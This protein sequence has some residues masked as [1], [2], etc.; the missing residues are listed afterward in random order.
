M[1]R[2]PKKRIILSG[3]SPQESSLESLV[4]ETVA[5]FY[6]LRFVA[7]QIHQQGETS[8]PKRGLLK[9]LERL[10]PQ[11]VPQ[12]ARIRPVSRQYI[13]TI[14]NQLHAGGYVTYLEN[15]AHKRS[16][17]I[18]LNQKGNDLLKAMSRRE[19]ELLSQLK[20]TLSQKELDQSASLLR[21]VRLIFENAEWNRLV[22][23]EVHKK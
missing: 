20:I 11:T 6:R 18:Q 12:M 2:T 23:G 14:V 17:L 21:K 10:G 19:G 9:S 8:G 22:A 15:P 4:N 5:L 7:E 13:Q 16:P 1:V 3:A